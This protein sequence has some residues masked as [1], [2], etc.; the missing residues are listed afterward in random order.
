MMERPWIKHYD[1]WVPQSLDIPSHPVDEFLIRS[2]LKHPK[3]TATIFGAR[4]GSFLL[5]TKMTYKE[6]NQKVNRFASGLQKMGVKPG[7]RVVLILPNCPQFIIAAYAIW[8]IGAIVV[9]CN[10]LYTPREIEYLVQDSGAETVIVL[11]SI[12]ERVKEVR[13]KID[14]PEVVVTNIK[15]FFPTSLK[16]LFTMTKEKKEGHRVDV[17]GDSNVTWF[18]NILRS[19]ESHPKPAF[20]D[21]DQTALLIYTGGTTGKPKGAEL[22]HRNLVSNASTV[23]TWAKSRPGEDILVACMPFFHIYGLTIGVN[24]CVA[25]AMTIL[26][27]PNPRDLRHELL[28]IEKHKA[29]FFPGVPTLFV[30]LN[31]FPDVERFDL[32]SLRFAASGAAPLAPEIQT[33]FQQLTGCEMVEAYGATETAPVATMDPI[34]RPKPHTV[35]V[36]MPDT[37]VCIVDISDSSVEMP[38][39]ESGEV[40]IKGPQ[41]M[42]GY[43]NKPEETEMALGSGPDGKKGWFHTGDIGVLDEDGYLSIV[44]RKKDLIIAGG[45]NIYPADVEEAIF[46]HPKVVE[47]A[48]IGVP[49]K[50]RGETVKAFVVLKENETAN[51]GEILDFCKERLAVYKVPKSLEFLDELPKS[52]IGKVLRRELREMELKKMAQS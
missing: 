31:H 7:D 28:A 26:L 43:W 18:Q 27:I 17:S 34:G 4:V 33:K 13:Q 49:D 20:I 50:K 30:G 39:G 46:E 42:K 8:R 41:V 40:L 52:L 3:I 47:A 19:G 25:N 9:C 21:Q 29:T 22:T 2:A 24:T 11:S 32:S 38:Q 37:Q 5:D 15:E 16:T 51:E 12:Y 44:D 48:V 1:K 35:G 14:I 10:P 6:L 23:N 36:P 45:Y